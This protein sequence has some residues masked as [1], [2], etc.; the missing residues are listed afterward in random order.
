METK[1]IR[2][3]QLEA[4]WS[5][6]DTSVAKLEKPLLENDPQNFIAQKLRRTLFG[7]SGLQPAA[8]IPCQQFAFNCDSRKFE[9][10]ERSIPGVARK[11]PRWRARICHAAHEIRTVAIRDS[12]Q[13][14]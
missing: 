1:P 11:N 2:Q 9:Q 13:R 3:M 10:V 4:H 12:P 5:D 6:L 8:A 7:Q 14:P